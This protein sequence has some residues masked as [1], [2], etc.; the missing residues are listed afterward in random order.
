MNVMLEAKNSGRSRGA[1]S[2]GAFALVELLVVIA[3]VGL[4]ASML[5]PALARAKMKAQGIQ[6]LSN[7]KQLTLAWL[8]YADNNRDRIPFTAGTVGNPAVWCGGRQDYD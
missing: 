5:L 3:I 1:S 7:H 2:Y 4:L 6:C 8:L